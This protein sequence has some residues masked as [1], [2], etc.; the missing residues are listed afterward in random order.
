MAHRKK[1]RFENNES[2]LFLMSEKNSFVNNGS[3]L[4]ILKKDGFGHERT[5][6]LPL[7]KFN[8]LWS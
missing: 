4:L 5:S 8:K 2:S 1:R 6:L 3:S 7:L